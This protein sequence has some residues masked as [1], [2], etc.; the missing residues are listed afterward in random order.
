MDS[1]EYRVR[2]YI[3]I[4]WRNERTRPSQISDVSKI[5]SGS[6]DSD[7]IIAGSRVV[8]DRC[9]IRRIK[10]G[11]ASCHNRS[12]HPGSRTAISNLCFASALITYG[13]GHPV[14]PCTHTYT[15]SLHPRVACLR[16][17]ALVR[18][19]D[20]PFWSA[21]IRQRTTW[22]M[23]RTFFPR[24]MEEGFHYRFTNFHVY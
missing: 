14:D 4:S 17:R 21:T 10:R 12:K 19:C 5:S 24:I 7:Y 1:H 16:A 9:G 13:N 8:L 20:L 15:R 11:P 22:T 6:G 2:R 3:I 18:R 23:R